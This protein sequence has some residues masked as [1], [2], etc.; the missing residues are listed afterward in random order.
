[1][2][3]AWQ[4][5]VLAAMY[6]FEPRSWPSRSRG[7]QPR[8]K[9]Q[10]ANLGSPISRKS[11]GLVAMRSNAAFSSTVGAHSAALLVQPSPMFFADRIRL[12]EMAANNLLIT[13]VGERDYA[14]AGGLM[15]YGR[16][17]TQSCK[18]EAPGDCDEI[19]SSFAAGK[20]DDLIDSS[21]VLWVIRQAKWCF[22]LRRLRHAGS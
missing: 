1:M 17:C 12:A 9:V 13:M 7:G 4:D 21:R 5:T 3:Q 22:Q 20:L 16:T 11:Q 15:V 2:N 14:E 18:P 19:A 8:A 10:G 6:D